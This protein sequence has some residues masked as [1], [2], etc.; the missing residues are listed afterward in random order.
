MPARP[1]APVTGRAEALVPCSSITT[2]PAVAAPRAEKFS[3]LLGL[4]AGALAPLLEGAGR[5][6]LKLV[7]KADKCDV[8]FKTGVTAK[9]FRNDDT[10]V[11]IDAENLDVA[12]E[13]DR[14]FVPLVRIVRQAR[15]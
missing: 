4:L 10:P 5:P 6:D 1:D 15:E 7:A 11:A 2:A 3:V 8:I 13:R 12:V 9:A 14:E